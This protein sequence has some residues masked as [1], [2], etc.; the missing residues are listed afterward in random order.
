M[1]D[2]YR[3]R[4]NGEWYDV[5]ADAVR[6]RPNTFGLA[7]VWYYRTYLNGEKSLISIRCVLPRAGG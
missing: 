4:I 3:V 6:G 1:A 7:V 5:P 2:H